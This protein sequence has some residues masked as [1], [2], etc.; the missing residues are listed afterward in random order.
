M[1]G[2]LGSGATLVALCDTD[3]VQIENKPAPRPERPARGGERRQGYGDYRRLLEDAKNYD[4]VLIG[5]PDH[6]HAPL[7][8]AFMKAGKPDLL[9]E[10]LTPQ[11]R[12]GAE[13][14]ELAKSTGVVTQM[15]NQGSASPSAARCIELI[16][17]GVLGQVR[18]VYHWGIGSRRRNEGSAPRGP[19]PRRG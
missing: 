18:E 10:A 15:G 17:A 1:K 19:D 4:A 11:R 16:K 7:C 9:R 13:L 5:T 8:K 2:L 12:R 14:R 3:P 6:W